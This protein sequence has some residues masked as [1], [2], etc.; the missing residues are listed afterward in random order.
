MGRLAL[1]SQIARSVNPDIKIIIS[2]GWG[3]NDWDYINQDYI[4]RANL[5]V[6]SVIQFIRS[7]KLDGIDI[8]NE[9]IGGTS[10]SISQT[11]FDGVIANLR[12]AL[13]YASLLSHILH[14]LTIVLL[15]ILFVKNPVVVQF[16]RRKKNFFYA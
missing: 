3:K 6:P 4:N 9:E 2:L 15:N 1:L 13:N 8:D 5:F 7:N 16:D 11:N 12:N 10:G 14:F